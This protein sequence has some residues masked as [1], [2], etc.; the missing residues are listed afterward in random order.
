MTKQ[1]FAREKIGLLLFTGIFGILLI[2]SIILSTNTL[3]TVVQATGLIVML[4]LFII[5]ERIPISPNQLPA[6]KTALRERDRTPSQRKASLLGTC[7]FTVYILTTNI[8][9]LLG[10]FDSTLSFWLVLITTPLLGI[11]LGVQLASFIR[12]NRH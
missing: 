10:R 11:V 8:S 1:W 5:S 7:V 9:Q 3:Q 12:L 6:G 4:A 2:I